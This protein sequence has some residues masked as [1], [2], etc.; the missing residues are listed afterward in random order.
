M[1]AL[2]PL[3]GT[4][5]VLVAHPDDELIAC[6]ALMQ[7]MKK[8]VVIFATDGAPYD[9]G[10]WKQYGSRQAYAGVRRKEAELALSS[11]RATALFLG[12]HVAGGIADQQLFRN[13]RPAIAALER[14]ITQVKPECILTLAYEGGHPDH[15]A[16]CF[17][18]SVVGR[19]TGIPVWEAP[20]Y[21]RNGAGA[22]VTQAFPQTTGTESE[23][24]IEGVAL[25]KKVQMFGHYRSQGPLFDSFGPE[26]ETFRPLAD[27]D[28]TQP[29]LPGKLN[30]EAWQWKMTGQEVSAAFSAFLDAEKGAGG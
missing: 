3:L 26:R 21:H 15:D 2:H 25:E 11:I 18:S 7:K 13:L 17:I 30:Y 8:A 24:R 6:G 29:P 22:T 16:V 5:L 4:T 14:I 27:Y 23:A 10:F 12:D 19:R 9:E 20:L 28:F 1:H